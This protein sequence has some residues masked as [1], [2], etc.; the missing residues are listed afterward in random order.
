MSENEIGKGEGSVTG[1]PE[2]MA[3]AK[4]EVKEKL[5]SCMWTEPN[6]FSPF[7]GKFGEN[8]SLQ[9]IE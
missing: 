7:R 6:A 1:A 2:L 9:L 4:M 3:G 8:C 5:S